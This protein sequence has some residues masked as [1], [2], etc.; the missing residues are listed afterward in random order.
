MATQYVIEREFYFPGMR[1]TTSEGLSRYARHIA[2][3]AYWRTQLTPPSGC[4][5]VIARPRPSGSGRGYNLR[6]GIK[7]RSESMVAEALIAWHARQGRHDLPW[8]SDRTP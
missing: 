8:Q 1:G 5:A 4:S 3:G 7:Q 2:E 6:V